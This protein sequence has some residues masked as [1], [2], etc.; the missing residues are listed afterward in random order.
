MQN[1]WETLDN[2]LAQ[3]TQNAVHWEKACNL[4]VEIFGAGGVIFAPTDPTFRGQWM[5]CS[6]GLK[7]TLPEYLAGGWHLNDSREEVTK[8]V[9]KNGYATDADIFPDKAAR[10]EIPIYKEFLCKHNFGVLTGLKVMTPNGYWC[11]FIH[12][13]NDHP[14][15]DDMQI[16]KLEKLRLILEAACIEAYKTALNKISQF[17]EFFNA[18][19][20]EVFVLD[21]QGDQ[22]L[23]MNQ[24][25]KLINETGVRSLL[26]PDLKQQM[27]KELIE[28][29][30]SNQDLSLSTS[31]SFH[32]DNQLITVLIVQA[33]KNLRHFFMPFKVCAIRTVCS[34]MQAY[35]LKKLREEY[36]LTESESMTLELL[37]AGKKSQTISSLLGVKPSTVRQRLKGIY[38]KTNVSSQVEL[39]AL[40][41][42]L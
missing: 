4:I 11:L 3:A 9:I 18:A 39:I 30:S 34:D 12:F 33:P 21:A 20:S 7:A 14:G 41:N 13:A 6:S 25:G 29:C 31:Y 37:S 32:N 28:L 5:S 23:R 17:A 35:R 2:V 38:A 42:Q 16:R 1:L 22:T 26:P 15:I 40:Y 24:F 27:G 10:F 19:Q 8:L 36:S